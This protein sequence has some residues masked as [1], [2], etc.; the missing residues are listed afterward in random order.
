VADILAK[1]L[2]PADM[3]VIER[4]ACIRQAWERVLG[5]NLQS[6]TRLVDYKGK[7]LWVEVASSPWMQEFQFLRPQILENLQTILGPQIVSDI[8]FRLGAEIQ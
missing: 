3:R 6:Q 7:V 8:R 5:E 2:K 1:I 4:R